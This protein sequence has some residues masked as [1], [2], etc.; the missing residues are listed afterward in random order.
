MADDDR[1][2]WPAA[3]RNRGPILAQ[4]QR[5]L[6]ARGVV[7]ELASG[8]GQHAAFFA[9]GLPHLDWQPTDLDEAML[10][11][12]RAW[13]DQSGCAN[14]RLPRI[15]DA[16]ALDW[17]TADAVVC[18]NMIHI[19]PWSCCLGLLDG[20]ART[21][22]DGAPLVLYGPFLEGEGTAPSNLAFDARLRSRDPTWGV[23]ALDEVA[24]EAASRGLH[25]D[26]VVEMP[27]NNRTVVLRATGS[28]PRRGA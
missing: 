28:R 19:A 22:S 24:A 21:L 7:L 2:I 14:L 16:R 3:E 10:P 8:P 20:A 5:V 9:A 4:L 15:L 23:R 26:E 17:P 18:I 13:R 11:S 1:Q 6:P 12:I 27:A 25:L